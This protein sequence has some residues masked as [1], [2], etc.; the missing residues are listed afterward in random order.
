MG[1]VDWRGHVCWVGARE[2]DCGDDE[3]PRKG[4]MFVSK[5]TRGRGGNFVSGWSES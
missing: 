5:G 2:V 1:E 4:G 3:H